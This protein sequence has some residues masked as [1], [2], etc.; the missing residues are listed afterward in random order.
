MDIELVPI[1]DGPT[2]NWGG[3]GAPH[4]LEVDED[5]TSPDVGDYINQS[6]NGSLECLGY[7]ATETDIDEAT[8]VKVT[9]SYSGGVSKGS[10]DA[11]EFKLYGNG[12]LKSTKVINVNTAD[13]DTIGWFVMPLAAPLT[14]L[15][16]DNLRLDKTLVTGGGVGEDEPNV[17]T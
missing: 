16:A 15:E 12:V 14:Q 6:I 4:Y 11:V 5:P 13:I 10:A 2:N 17:I 1:S 7:A 8:A 3:T 9:M